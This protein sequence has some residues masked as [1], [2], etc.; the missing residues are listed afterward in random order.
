MYYV[1]AFW[2]YLWALR[3]VPASMAGMFLNLI[4]VFGVSTA[5]VFLGE[6]L[7]AIQWIG[8]AAILLSIC[9][10]LGWQVQRPEAAR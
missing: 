10:L 9:A 8:A 2:F 5:Y 4:P 7:T 6:R 1:A 3:S